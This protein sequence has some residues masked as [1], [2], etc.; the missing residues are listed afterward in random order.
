MYEYDEMCIQVFL[1]QQL[2]LFPKKVAKTQEEAEDFLEMCMAVVC[3]NIKEVRE[4]LEEAGA[5]IAGMTKEDLEEA[6][7]VFALPDGRYLVVDA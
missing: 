1:E 4:Y 2:K 5:D 3:K 6:Q 7:E